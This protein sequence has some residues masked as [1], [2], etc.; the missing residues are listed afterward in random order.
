MSEYSSKWG[1]KLMLL[2]QEIVFLKKRKSH[3]NFVW[4]I[5][6]D[7]VDIVDS[8]VYLGL[9]LHYTGNMKYNMQSL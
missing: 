8:F 5:N 6:G 9:K 2:K 7:R 4:P 1:L 3:H